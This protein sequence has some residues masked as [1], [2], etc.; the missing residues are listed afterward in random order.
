MTNF[1]LFQIFEIA[2]DSFKFVENG[3]RY[4][5]QVRKRCGKSSHDRLENAVEKDVAC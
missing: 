4:S 1:R 2:A 5:W 3:R